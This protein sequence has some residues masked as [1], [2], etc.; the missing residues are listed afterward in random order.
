MIKRDKPI[1]RKENK[2]R[3]MYKTILLYTIW[4]AEQNIP[5]IEQCI[6][7]L[8]KARIRINNKINLLTNKLPKWTTNW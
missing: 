3:V 8:N 1:E 7:V 4:I 2:E 5:N 6:Y